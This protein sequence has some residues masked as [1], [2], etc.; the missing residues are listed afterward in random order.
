MKLQNIFSALVLSVSLLSVQSCLD[1]DSP[2]DEFQ[3]T[4]VVLDDVIH[5]GK[6]DSIDYLHQTTQ[7]GLNSAIAELSHEVL[8]QMLTAQYAMRGGK[9]GDYP[10]PHA[11]QR[12]FTLGPD[13]YA[14]FATIPHQDFMYGTLTSTYDISLDFNP[15]PNSSYLIVKNAL[16]PLL[17]HPQVD[18]IPELKAIGLL[19]LDYSSQE[20][21]D[22][23]GPF[24]YEDFKKNRT[25]APFTYNDL[26]TIYK[27]IEAN[28]D[29]IINCFRHYP[30][31]PDWYKE[32]LQ[33]IL[34]QYTVVN[35]DAQNGV[36][37]MDTWIRLA[38]SLK[39][40]M[41]MHIVKVEPDM[42][43]QW[44]EEAVEVGVVESKEQESAISLV[45]IGKDHPLLEIWTSW[46]DARL[47]A[48]FE[49]I[50]MSLQH[51][52][53]NY[54]FKKNSDPIVDVNTNEV[55]EA[56]T[57][58]TGIREGA[59]TGQGQSY[60]NNQYIAF[61]S[62]E[63]RVISKAP[64]YLMKWSEVDFLR[65][66]GALRG[67]NMGGTAQF[68]YERGIRNGYLDNPARVNKTFTGGIDDY[69]KL[70]QAVD[71][72][73]VDPTGETPSMPSVTKIGVK[74]N[75]GDDR[76][77]KLEKIIT[78]K[79]IAQFPYSF[80][81]W[82]DLRRTGYPRVFPVLNPDD[83]DGSLLYGDIIRRMPFPNNDDSSL[84]D[85]QTTGLK[86]LGGAD[87]QATRLWWDVNEPN[88]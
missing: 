15:G 3:A 12:Q 69:L 44:A 55:L 58:I 70:E 73:Y 16:V 20:V 66:E 71:Y 7:E 30:T 4:D 1:F 14:Q 53:A 81:A 42:A 74:W 2:S 33:T 29:T 78:Q 37:T 17:N 39:L 60:G 52:Y 22:L 68:F 86:A 51:P 83:G 88:F 65:A 76:E 59:H 25:E 82:T 5:F 72:T 21:A 87:L 10:G 50:L 19:L 62:L 45:Q 79:Y 77:T 49:S 34:Q 84:R 47:S 64:L 56:D 11:Y 18:S 28:L 35:Q 8:G 85:I 27:G 54:L 75:D 67:W 31:R 41:A 6:A 24:P 32:R 13:N 43:R 9:D 63:S 46:S 36:E 61:S 26:P 23:Y 40:R 38:A 80:E 48:S 57:R